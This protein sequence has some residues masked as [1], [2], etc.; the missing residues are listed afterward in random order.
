M[1]GLLAVSS[2]TCLLTDNGMREH[3]QTCTTPDSSQIGQILRENV[4]DVLVLVG[5]PTNSLRLVRAFRRAAPWGYV[6]VLDSFA[7]CDL[8]IALEQV[9]ELWPLAEM[10]EVNARLEV[11]QRLAEIN[12][13]WQATPESVREKAAGPGELTMLVNGR[14][15]APS[16]A[17]S[18]LLAQLQ[19]VLTTDPDSP[20]CRLAFFPYGWNQWTAEAAASLE[21]ES[22]LDGK[23]VLPVK[24]TFLG[25][26]YPWGAVRLASS[27]DERFSQ[28][29]E[30]I[31]SYQVSNGMFRLV[32]VLQSL[33]DGTSREYALQ[34]E[35]VRSAILQHEIGVIKGQVSRQ[36][37]L[38]LAGE[39]AAGVAHEIRNPLT[40]VRGFIQLLKQKLER[41]SMT[42]EV[43]YADY[44]LE[45]IDRANQII[46][47]FLTMAKP[48]EEQWQRV[49]LTELLEDMSQLVQHQAILGGVKLT[50]DLCS[51]VPEI[52]AKGEALKQVFLNLLSNALQATADGGSIVLRSEL[53]PGCV[54]VH[55]QDTGVGI[56]QERICRIF[57]PFYT[58][59]QGGTG[60]GLAICREI[61]TEHGGTITVDSVKNAGSV[62]TVQ[63]PLAARQS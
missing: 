59:K 24:L 26:D 47:D 42:T 41:T 53:E 29:V 37:K 34:I 4:P 10:E 60:L 2:T 14:L 6:V 15:L 21:S 46:T 28:V 9:D 51:A 33:V 48:K 5:A 52:R 38:A 54:K 27:A 44:I 62:F 30:R 20:G 31:G 43:R 40:A 36:G 1:A 58:T 18:L 23:E 39:L 57:E 19:Q 55:V 56:E 32:H 11:L 63:L 25:V 16:R 17:V 8:G 7:D 35:R 12:R 50:V 45:E 49:N 3:I 13:S 61:L 22:I